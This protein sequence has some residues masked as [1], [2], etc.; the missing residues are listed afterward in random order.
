MNGL[1]GWIADVVQSL[2]Y[3]GIAALI[4]LVARR[5]HRGQR[6]PSPAGRPKAGR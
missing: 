6:P 3:V 5:A 1:A 4:A 2:G